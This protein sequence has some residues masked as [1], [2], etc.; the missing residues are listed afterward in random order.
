MM[1]PHIFEYGEN[2]RIPR[3]VLTPKLVSLVVGAP[4]H[5]YCRNIIRWYNVSPIQLSPNSYMLAAALFILY[6]DQGFPA[7]TMEEFSYFFSIRKSEKGY[8]FF[9]VQKKHNK[10][11]ILRR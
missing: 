1:R 6:F 11:K 7:P 2:F 3:M 10:K 5:S 4:I 8:F 9:V